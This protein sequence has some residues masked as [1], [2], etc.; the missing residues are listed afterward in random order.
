MQWIGSSANQ[1]LGVRL[2]VVVAGILT[3]QK[4]AVQPR[5]TLDWQL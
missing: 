2:H 4:S 1:L 5:K 3:A